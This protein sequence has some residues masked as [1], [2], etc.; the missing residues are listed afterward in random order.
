MANFK[1]IYSLVKYVDDTNSNNVTDPFLKGFLLGEAK[2]IGYV[3]ESDC[4]AEML[5]NPKNTELCVRNVIESA[6]SSEHPYLEAYIVRY[7]EGRRF[8]VTAGKG[9][10]FLKRKLGFKIGVWRDIIQH[11]TSYTVVISVLA[12]IVSIISVVIAFIHNG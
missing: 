3:L 10:D 1:L 8:G 6:L 7:G 9:Q 5:K 4:I 12:L 11:Y 2:G